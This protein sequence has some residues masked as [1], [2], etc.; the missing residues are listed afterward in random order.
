MSSATQGQ[1]DPIQALLD[2]TQGTRVSLSAL[3]RR[4]RP[5]ELRAVSATVA[6]AACSRAGSSRSRAPRRAPA[7]LVPGLLAGS[8]PGG[9]A[10]VG[11]AGRAQ[12]EAIVAADRAGRI[13]A[14]SLGSARDVARARARRSCARTGSSSPACRPAIP[15]DVALD[16]LI[17]Q[18]ARRTSC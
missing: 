14:V 18:R 8:I 11:V 2:I 1:Y 10:Y 7:E 5:P 4:K 17:E 6:A 12:R 9:A 13:A 3:L 16:E 15:G